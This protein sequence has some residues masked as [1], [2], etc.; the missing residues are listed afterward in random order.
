MHKKSRT[1]R[2][3]LQFGA[4]DL[5][6]PDYEDWTERN[7]SHTYV[8]PQFDNYAAYFDLAILQLIK[9]IQYSERISPMCLPQQNDSRTPGVNFINVLCTAFTHVDPKRLKKTVMSA[10][11]FCTF[12]L[13][14]HKSCT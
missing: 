13:R 11:S 10:L 5:K 7:I 6:N 8:H 2:W 1:F 9:P 3:C 14:E 12:G 4:Y